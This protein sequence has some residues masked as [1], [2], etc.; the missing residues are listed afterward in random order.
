MPAVISTRSCSSC[1]RGPAISA[2]AFGS[3]CSYQLPATLAVLVRG[4]RSDGN[5]R[6]CC[7]MSH[8]PGVPARHDADLLAYHFGGSRARS[9]LNVLMTPSRPFMQWP[10]FARLCG[11][12]ASGTVRQ[13]LMQAI[14]VF[15]LICIAASLV[16]SCR[17]ARLGLSGFWVQ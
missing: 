17:S 11:E 8:V 3:A 10:T 12:K 7:L 1:S 9:S 4:G 14:P 13:F 2:I 15:I 5:L 6:P 16:G